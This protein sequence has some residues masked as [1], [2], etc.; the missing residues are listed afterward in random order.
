MQV[1]YIPAQ[2]S[3][4]A[5]GSG[6]GTFSG[7]GRGRWIYPGPT[8][9]LTFANGTTVTNQNYANVLSSFYNIQSGADLR[10]KYFTPPRGEPEP[11]ESIATIS[12]SSSIAAP[13]PITTTIP[14]PGYPSPFIRE[15]NNLNSGYF[16]E[17]EGY[18]D[19]AVLAV[20][21]FVGTT[22]DELPFQEIN[23]Y[24]LNQAVAMGKK[25]LIIDVSANG[26]GTILQGYDLFKQLFPS[27]L[28]YGATRF[29]AHQVCR[30][31]LAILQSRNSIAR[32]PS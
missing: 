10:R 12:S 5:A 2:V 17:G 3:L 4:G 27:I 25:K 31:L 21:S 24:F 26:G 1:F 6:T 32:V 19:V 14:A 7:G 22:D 29:R 20:P 15:P 9:T 11:V 13:T 23:T 18:D 16:L 8:T 30:M 28:P